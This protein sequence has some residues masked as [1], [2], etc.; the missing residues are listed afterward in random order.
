MAKKKPKPKMQYTADGKQ[1]RG[2]LRMK[3]ED[4]ERLRDVCARAG[5][6]LQESTKKCRWNKT[7]AREMASKGGRARWKVQKLK[8]E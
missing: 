3:L 4:P 1:I 6:V 7:Q 2:F 8:P 5:R